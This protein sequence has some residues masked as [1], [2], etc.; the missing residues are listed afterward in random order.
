MRAGGFKHKE[1]LELTTVE[2][3]MK[4]EEV[5]DFVYLGVRISSTCQEEKE[6]EARLI[7]ANKSAVL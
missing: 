2:G 4:Y 5:K 1:L 3:K 6:V 7:K